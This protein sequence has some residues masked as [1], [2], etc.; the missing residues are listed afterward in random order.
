MVWQRQLPSSHRHR[1][2]M[3][4]VDSS[5]SVSVGG[6]KHLFV[7]THLMTP[8]SVVHR[9]PSEL[10]PLHH[11]GRPPRGASNNTTTTVGSSKSSTIAKEER[12]PRELVP[13]QQ[14]QQQKHQLQP[15]QQ[16][17]QQQHHFFTTPRPNPSSDIPTRIGVGED[18]ISDCDD[19]VITL[20][21]LRTMESRNASSAKRSIYRSVRDTRGT[22]NDEYASSSGGGDTFSE[23]V[24][25]EMKRVQAEM[26]GSGAGSS[27][28]VA[29][30][31]SRTSKATVESSREVQSLNNGRIGFL[32]QEIA[33]ARRRR[34]GRGGVRETN[35]IKTESIDYLEQELVNKRYERRHESEVSEMK[36]QLRSV[37]QAADTEI[38]ELKHQLRIMGQAA[39]M[40]ISDLK[41]QLR[42]MKREADLEISD[43]KQQ[44]RTAAQLADSEIS[45]LKQYIRVTED[46]YASKSAA[47]AENYARQL[48]D[49]ERKYK[50]DFVGSVAENDLLR[51]E[52]QNNQGE[53]ETKLRAME[54]E[55]ENFKNRCEIA[56]RDA[57]LSQNLVREM[58]S[59]YKDALMDKEKVERMESKRL[60]MM[61]EMTVEL[62]LTL[63][64]K[65]D[66]LLRY[67]NLR[68]ETENY[69]I[70]IN[71][72]V[73]LE[74]ENMK[75]KD[76]LE[77]IVR[78]CDEMRSRL[79]LMDEM[80]ETLVVTRAEMDDATLRCNSLLSEQKELQTTTESVA[81]ALECA[82]AEKHEA[83]DRCIELGRENTELRNASDS[84]SQLT[85]MMTQQMMDKYIDEIDELKKNNMEIKRQRDELKEELICVLETASSLQR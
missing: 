64:E 26:R 29:S 57:E 15:L 19:S 40:E 8:Q 59:K 50:Y 34:E 24:L 43:L 79:A 27:S 37:E 82:L 48:D 12:K 47:M 83:I 11:S 81:H 16:T 33:N 6:N 53:A 49:L 38:A 18:D 66:V 54:R 3:D 51:E 30:I 28:S 31:S 2:E 41:K 20:Q 46:E 21:T 44:L 70:L 55:C 1:Q 17:Q 23:K 75:L 9:M 69:P 52:M 85:D 32:K 45:E 10:P 5:S 22:A 61:E 13:Q 36:Q 78:E 56:E 74:R 7:E 25:R 84:A 63:A 60:A 14:Q 4:V 71:D 72:N 80:T 39:D 67:N 65:E 62:E 68:D 35:G 73:Q 42:T 58:E 77:C 76:E